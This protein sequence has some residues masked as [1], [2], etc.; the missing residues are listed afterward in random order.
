[1]NLP[2]FWL[3]YNNKFFPHPCGILILCGAYAISVSHTI[4]LMINLFYSSSPTAGG[5]MTYSINYLAPQRESLQLLLAKLSLLPGI[6]KWKVSQTW[7][8][9]KDICIIKLPRTARQQCWVFLLHA[10][11]VDVLIWQRLW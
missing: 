10:S 3:F 9:E 4:Q 1:M 2:N 8:S 7:K 5:W 6:N 11:Q